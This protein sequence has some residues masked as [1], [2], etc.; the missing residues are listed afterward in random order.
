[1]AL[2]AT[3]LGEVTTQ[4]PEMDEDGQVGLLALSLELQC[5]VVARMD[6][7]D[8]RS[9]V[10]T[11][12]AMRTVIHGMEDVFWRRCEDD[13][14]LF[15]LPESYREVRRRGR[16]IGSDVKLI[17][18]ES[19]WQETPWRETTLSR[20]WE[21]LAW[22][23]ENTGGSV[24][25]L[26]EDELR[27]A[28]E[29]WPD[30]QFRDYDCDPRLLSGPDVGDGKKVLAYRYFFSEADVEL[31]V[32]LPALPFFLARPLAYHGCDCLISH[33][34]APHDGDS[35]QE[36][37]CK[38]FS[39]PYFLDYIKDK[40][41]RALPGKHDLHTRYAQANCVEFV[42]WAGEAL[43][44]LL[45]ACER[46]RRPIPFFNMSETLADT[47]ERFAQ[48]LRFGYIRGC[49]H[50]PPCTCNVLRNYDCVPPR[51]RGR[52]VFKGDLSLHYT[53]GEALWSLAQLLRN[54]LLE[55]GG[56]FYRVN[57]LRSLFFYS[58]GRRLP[59]MEEPPPSGALLDPTIVRVIGTLSRGLEDN[60]MDISGA[61]GVLQAALSELSHWIL[62][63]QDSLDLKTRSNAA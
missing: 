5:M 1:M 47:H 11:C 41:E 17:L 46:S 9:L 18:E 28:E 19:L 14:G 48:F 49:G 20:G 39:L 30:L 60:A 7:A 38:W 53:A 54:G 3:T 50:K 42:L 24:R 61:L 32:S 12:T 52:D 15:F 13:Y 55:D 57:P 6:A 27:A 8:L 40:C 25:E 43:Y 29:R 62:E 26:T 35:S 56:L 4:Q 63:R 16:R 22:L 34:V 36:E 23:Q 10:C 21:V 2:R 45:A 44:N 37:D 51:L 33:E 31:A 58:T 59:D